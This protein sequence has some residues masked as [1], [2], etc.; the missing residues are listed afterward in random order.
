MPPATTSAARTSGAA[1]S[2]YTPAPSVRLPAEAVYAG[3]ITSGTS[4]A[5]ARLVQEWLT[6]SG[7]GVMV[8]GEFGPA[9]AAAVRVFQRKVKLPSTG[10]VDHA[11]FER[12]VAPMAA[13][14]ATP[15]FPSGTAVGAAVVAVAKQHLAQHPREAGG[16]NRGPWVRL[17]MD[18]NQGPAWPWCAGFATFVVAQ[19]CAALGQPLPVG[20]TFS[21]DVLAERARVAGRLVQGRPADPTRGIAPGS[22]FLVRRAPGDW[23]HVGIVTAARPDAFHTIEGNTNDAGDREGY[24]VCARVRGYERK[25]F[26]RIA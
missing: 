14:L 3:D 7:V 8:D 16:Q 18:G 21:C 13:A 4:G 12:L 2:P 20:R 9:T 22:L 25:D 15:A 23:D 1:R 5:R 11:T 10:V 19:A 6:L 26:V 24:E 17:Y